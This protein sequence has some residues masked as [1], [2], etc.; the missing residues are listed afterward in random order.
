MQKRER[1][2]RHRPVK[3]WP[4]G[5]G[6]WLGIADCEMKK[7]SKT[8]R[9]AKISKTKVAR[10]TQPRGKTASSSSLIKLKKMTLIQTSRHLEGIVRSAMD[11]IIMIDEEQRVTLFNKAAEQMFGIAESEMIGRP[12]ERL[13]P[14]RFRLHHSDSVKKF[15]LT[16]S[17]TRAMGRLGEIVGLRS[18]GEEFPIEATV[19]QSVVGGVRVFAVIL[20]DISERKKA[21]NAIV[22]LNQKTEMILQSAGEGIYGIDG[23][24]KVTFFNLAAEQLTGWKH[25]SIKGKLMHPLMHHSRPDGSPY[26][27]EECPIYATL[28]DGA[29]HTIEN[30]VLWRKDGSSFYAVYTSTP[31]IGDRGELIGAVVTFSDVTERNRTREQLRHAERLAELGTLT[32]GM[33]HEIG[34]PMNVILGRAEQLLNKTEEEPTKKGLRTIVSQVERITK[35]MNQL[36]AFARRRKGETRPINLQK[37]IEECLEVLLERLDRS[38]IK[39]KPSFLSTPL[40]ISA[41]PDQ[42]TQVFFNLFMN[43]IQAMPEQGTLHV[44]L[45]KE[46]DIGIVKVSDT[47]EGIPRENLSKIFLPF[48]TT[49]ESGQGTGLGLSIV[50]DIIQEH[51]GTIKVHSVLRKGTTFII[52]FPIG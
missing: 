44:E 39:V 27:Q 25:S 49:K 9:T 32:S 21:E 7:K 26:P 29:I 8:T 17:T 46:N 35:I 43:A 31:M 19:S 51:G 12:I 22:A 11:G 3:A 50:K 36:L 28:V 13:M 16:N 30:E 23:N 10:R 40:I 41:D 47:G 15:G 42:M 24:G 20:R 2:L 33:A 5:S 14:E 4:I 18:N 48:F 45:T 52:T 38:G 6:Y 1:L 34:T 37:V